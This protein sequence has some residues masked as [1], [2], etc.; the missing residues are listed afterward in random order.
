MRGA[1]APGIPDGAGV[2]KSLIRIAQIGGFLAC[3]Q[4]GIVPIMSENVSLLI[5][6]THCF[7]FWSR[8]PNPALIKRH[9]FPFQFPIPVT[10]IVNG[11]ADSERASAHYNCTTY[12]R[13][14]PTAGHVRVI[15]LSFG[16]FRWNEIILLPWIIEVSE[17]QLNFITS[18]FHGF[19]IILFTLPVVA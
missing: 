3:W 10:V 1:R 16:S 9:L 5:H 18:N 19:C 7:H 11:Q 6:F 8:K 17:I 4:R 2:I 14:Q 12:A 15:E 13:L